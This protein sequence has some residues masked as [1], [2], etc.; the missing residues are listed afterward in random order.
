MQVGGSKGYNSTINVTPLVDVVLVLLITFMV[1]TPMLQSGKAVELPEVIHVTEAKQK[2][3]QMKVTI[4]ADGSIYR[5]DELVSVGQL[6]KAIKDRMS[7]NP[8]L[9]VVVKGD[10][11]LDYIQVRKVMLACRDAGAKSVVLATKERKDKV[12]RE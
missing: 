6:N 2:R 3:E 10:R 8:G 1:V 5:D 12:P 7:Y 11:S 9:E 4:T